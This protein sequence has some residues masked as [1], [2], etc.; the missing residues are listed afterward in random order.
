MDSNDY[1]PVIPLETIEVVIPTV[2]TDRTETGGQLIAFYQI[3]QPTPVFVNPPAQPSINAN[4]MAITTGD[5]KA[6]E[7]VRKQRKNHRRNRAIRKMNA[8]ANLKSDPQELKKLEKIAERYEEKVVI[9]VKEGKRLSK[10]IESTEKGSEEGKGNEKGKGSE[11][12]A[13]T[14]AMPNPVA[15]AFEKARASAKKSIRYHRA[16]ANEALGRPFDT[17]PEPSEKEVDKL[18]NKCL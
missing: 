5:D 7:R 17:I 3:A 11:P 15:K 13:S 9:S 1:L 14:S 16:A 6:R 18:I 8:H 10:T 2:E 12:G 4:L